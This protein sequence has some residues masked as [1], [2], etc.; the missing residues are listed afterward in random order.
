MTLCSCVEPIMNFVTRQQVSRE[1]AREILQKHAEKVQEILLEHGYESELKMYE[2]SDNPNFNIEINTNPNVNFDPNFCVY[3]QGVFGFDSIGH[4]SVSASWE[5]DLTDMSQATHDFD[6]EIL[7]EVYEYLTGVQ[8]IDK[9]ALTDF[10]N[11]ESGK[12]YDPKNE[13]EFIDREI[14]RYKYDLVS[15]WGVSYRV[16]PCSPLPRVAQEHLGMWGIAKLI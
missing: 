13:G 15:D 6:L 5:K 12:Y 11:D 16:Q 7:L 2:Y 14:N 8:W 4:M 9:D 1:Q 10:L 3:L